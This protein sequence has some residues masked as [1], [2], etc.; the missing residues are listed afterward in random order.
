MMNNPGNIRIDEIIGDAKSVFVCGHVRPDGDCTGASLGLYLYLKKNRPDVHVDV[1]LETVWPKFRVLDGWDCIKTSAEE[2]QYD[3]FICLD[4]ADAGR[5][6]EARKIIEKSARTVCIDHHVTNNAFAQENYLNSKASSTSEIVC[7]LLDEKLIDR[8]VAEP[9]YMGLVHDTGVFQYDCTSPYTMRLA[10]MLLE[11]G[12]RGSF[13]I[14]KTF[15][16]KTYRQNRLLGY[17]LDHS[18]LELDGRCIVSVVPLSEMKKRGADSGDTE[19]IV[20]QLRIT[21]GV[22]AAVF[23]YE[24]EQNVFKVSLR[25]KMYA[26]V[27]VVA[28][29]FGGGGH[30][31]AA[32]CTCRGEAAEIIDNLLAV[33]GKQFD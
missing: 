32:G 30:V 9:L 4:C 5:I 2:K 27:S 23:L 3:L 17:A 12:V 24:T 13:I 33:L 6:G 8:T 7:G 11:K 16:E 21:E 19:G 14:D 10:A 29:H 20:S 28:A 22:E 15:Y 1:F 18:I 31:R 26:D 25:S